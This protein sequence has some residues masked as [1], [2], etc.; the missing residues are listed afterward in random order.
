MQSPNRNSLSTNQGQH[1]THR[2]QSL[3]SHKGL[4]LTPEVSQVSPLHHAK[5][6]PSDLCYLYALLF[7]PTE[8]LPSLFLLATGVHF[9]V[10]PE[11]LNVPG[12]LPPSYIWHLPYFAQA[13]L[14][15]GITQGLSWLTHCVLRSFLQYN[16]W[17]PWCT[18]TLSSKSWPVKSR[19][20]QA[21][22]F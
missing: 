1:N 17:A 13:V 5:H 4:G 10:S 15:S 21:H 7:W 11:P 12:E 18:L 8:H 3:L 16:F 20:C 6:L 2:T 14:T 9:C 22:C 19:I